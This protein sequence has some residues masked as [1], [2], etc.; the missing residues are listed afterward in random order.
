MTDTLKAEP[1]PRTRTGLTPRQRRNFGVGGQYV[2]LVAVVVIAIAVV[3][4]SRIQDNFFNPDMLGKV[5]PELFTIGLVNTVIYTVSGYALG[6]FL[7]L[8]IAVMRLSSL[9]LNRLL[10]HGYIEIFRGVPALLVFLILAFGLPIAMPD[11]ELP[12]PPY[13]T[14][15]LALG[16]VSAAYMAET[17][18]AGIQAVPKGQIEAAR[19]LGMSA[20]RA[21]VTIVLP[22]A[23]RIV[24]PP[25]TNE[26]ILLFKDSSLVFAI[27]ITAGTADLSKI[28]NDLAT[29]HS[30]ST[31]FVLAGLTYLL[32]TVPLGY[33]VRR[34]EARQAKAR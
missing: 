6:F 16:L 7:G 30:N 25:L 24:I 32:I 20:P 15:A 11:R 33:V 12:F 8:L 2:A 27:G 22:Q 34:L 29:E 23:I 9:R 21:M 26:L 10:A 14:V 31:P 18:R 19:S 1:G 3:D 4:W 28:G 5:W 13:G 17:F